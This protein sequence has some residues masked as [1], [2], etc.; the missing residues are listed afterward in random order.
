MQSKFKEGDKVRIIHTGIRP[1][2][3][4]TKIVPAKKHILT[5]PPLY[6]CG[7]NQKWKKFSPD[8]LDKNVYFIMTE[9]PVKSFSREEYE[10]SLPANWDL[11]EAEIDLL[12]E[13]EPT[14]ILFAACEDDLQHIES[15]NYANSN[16]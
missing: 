16:N 1:V 7:I 12:Y 15:K 3:I 13:A 6:R 10:E 14:Q 9:E 4:I 2:G 11:T 8:W 5:Y